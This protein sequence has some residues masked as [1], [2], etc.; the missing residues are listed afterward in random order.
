ML[1]LSSLCC[2]QSSRT[3]DGNENIDV[4]PENR[5]RQEIKTQ[6]KATLTN[7]GRRMN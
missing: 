5:S 2:A 1:D 3:K 7:H 6:E 4:A